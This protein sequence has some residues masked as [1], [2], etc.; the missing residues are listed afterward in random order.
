MKK[1]FLIVLVL[2]SY[3]IFSQ[4]EKV[5]SVKYGV[6]ITYQL[7]LEEEGGKKDKYI[8]IVNATNNS[9]N[10]LYY[11]IKIE[12]DDTVKAL[13][14]LMTGSTGFTKIKVRNSTGWFGDGKSISGAS[15]DFI[16][17]NNNRLYK[18]NAGGVYSQETTFKVRHGKKPILTNSFSKV[19][20]KLD[21]FNLAITPQMLTGNYVSSCGNTAI[22][23]TAKKSQD[24][25]DHLIQATNGKQFIWLK[26]A[27]GS[28][29]RE[30]NNGITLTYNK[31]T[32][33]YTYATLDGIS[34][35]WSKK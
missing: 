29:K 9:S 21:A 3:T 24:K 11:P 23:I 34:C 17:V 19:L 22:S 32:A 12:T 31:S 10:D 35:N 8:L 7:V 27:D 28:F 14:S 20:Q 25:G 18:L 30:N 6:K 1:L 5:L 4:E 16:T 33:S 15:T 2:T 26:T 13:N